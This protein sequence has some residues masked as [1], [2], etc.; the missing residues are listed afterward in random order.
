M[1]IY[2]FNDFSETNYLR[3][4]WNIFTIFSSNKRVMGE[5]ERSGPWQPILCKN[6]KLPT[7]V[8]HSETERDYAV[9]THD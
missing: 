3:I 9:Y 2:I 4:R 6:G 5:D 1:S 8:A 7:V